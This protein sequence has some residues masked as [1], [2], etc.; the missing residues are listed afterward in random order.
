M[1]VMTSRR[2]R[3]GGDSVFRSARSSARDRRLAIARTPATLA[4]H[5]YTYDGCCWLSRHVVASAAAAWLVV[6]AVRAAAAAWLAEEW[7]AVVEVLSVAAGAMVV[8]A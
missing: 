5:G 4:G 7:L 8:V 6:V 3:G 2:R 1:V